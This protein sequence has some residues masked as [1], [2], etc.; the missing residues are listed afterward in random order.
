MKGKAKSCGIS[1]LVLI[2]IIVDIC[3]A[4]LIYNI[5]TNS[6]IKQYGYAVESIKRD[7]DID[8]PSDSEL[9]FRVSDHGLHAGENTE[10][11]VFIFNNFDED[12]LT[13]ND[14]SCRDDDKAKAYNERTFNAEFDRYNKNNIVPNEYI[15]NFEVDYYWL[16]SV[17]RVAFF[18][19]YPD[20][21]ELIYYRVG[22]S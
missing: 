10:Y 13:Q 17:K 2:S 9:L 8:I 15:P 22:L 6:N 11:D 3:F 20:S 21:K 12:W 4:G 7:T 19:Y 18:I 16:E 5:Y 1:I 14:F